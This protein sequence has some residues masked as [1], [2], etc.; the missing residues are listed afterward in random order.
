M[1]DFIYTSNLTFLFENSTEPLFDSISFQIE[2]GWTGIAGANGSG[3]T[4]LLK[5]ICRQL[6][7]ESGSINYKGRS[8]YCEQRTDYMP[9]SFPDLLSSTDKDAVK[10][11]SRLQIK[12]EWQFR[13]AALSHGER[14]RCQTAAA[15]FLNP[16]VLAMDEPSNHLDR[17][18]KT[19]LYNALKFYKGIGLL[20]SHDRELLDNL[21]SHTLF[22]FPPKID[23]RKCSYTIAAKEIETENESRL[24]EFEL[25]GREVKKL[26]RRSA[27]QRE[28]ADRSDKKKSKKHISSKDHDAKSKKDLAKL[29]GKDAVDGR[30]YQRV[31]SQL[32]RSLQKKN[33]I[34]FRKKTTLGI[35]FNEQLTKRWFPVTVKSRTLQ[36]GAD[37]KLQ[38]PELSLE[39]GE[40]IGITG[41]NGSGKSTFIKHFKES[42]NIP[43]EQI[44]FIPQE[45]SQTDSAAI[46]KRIQ[47]YTK[48][49]LGHLM[50]IISRLGS[51][52]V[53]I[54]ETSIPSPGEIRKLMLAE[55]IIQ[56]PAV[57]I[58]DEPTNHMD[59][60]SIECVEDALQECGC[61]QLLVSHDFEFLKR[62]VDY[63]WAFNPAENGFR[64]QVETI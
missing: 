18:S 37:K 38:I 62:I 11:K 25:A 6:Q 12:D 53:H 35:T 41:D 48:D 7:P 34:Q 40:K 17:S 29:T 61:A 47:E 54:L 1:Q 39:S 33:S 3:K 24:R 63:F 2:K 8:I 45:I 4:T 43:L 31:Q 13:W 58:M 49:S 22:I 19:V 36:L 46:V 21:C 64:I 23:F 9:A 28:K 15:L 42:L 52:P 55:G 57:I 56:N 5:L 60:P 26:K 32:Q 10:I 20:V 14:K 30:I 51:D 44:I 59:L 50:T 27:R 16:A